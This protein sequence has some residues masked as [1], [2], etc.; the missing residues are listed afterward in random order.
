MHALWMTA[1]RAVDQE[2]LCSAAVIAFSMDGT[3]SPRHVAGSKLAYFH[4]RDLEGLP[5]G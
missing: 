2:Q 4:F 1:Q 3:F 5:V